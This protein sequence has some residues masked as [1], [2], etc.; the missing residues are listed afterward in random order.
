MELMELR[1]EDLSAH[2]IT[3]QLGLF[4]Q[5]MQ[6]EQ[7]FADK[8][9]FPI[10]QTSMHILHLLHLSLFIFNADFS[11]SLTHDTCLSISRQSR[12]QIFIHLKHSIAN[13]ILH[14]HI[15][16]YAEPQI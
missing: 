10:G 2:G 14:L 15:K 9:R 6:F 3:R 7:S 13:K 11:S 12:G 5:T 4:L 8:A 16:G 1:K